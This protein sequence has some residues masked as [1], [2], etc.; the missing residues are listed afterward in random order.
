MLEDAIR[1]QESIF[2]SWE[3]WTAFEKPTVSPSMR[4]LHKFN[5]Q[6]FPQQS[7]STSMRQMLVWRCVVKMHHQNTCNTCQFQPEIT[8]SPLAS[9]PQGRE[10]IIK[11]GDLK[12]RPPFLLWHCWHNGSWP[13]CCS[14]AE[15]GTGWAS[16][17]QAITTTWK[18]AP[19]RLPVRVHA[20]L[21][22]P[23]PSRSTIIQNAVPTGIP[24][25]ARRFSF[26]GYG[27]M[28]MI[29]F[30][31]SFTYSHLHFTQ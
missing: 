9:S 15:V 13:I 2:L 19:Q 27:A 31:Q 16:V 25:M 20:W 26:T 30:F 22:S 17:L 24:Q 10:L 29:T 4:H 11:P 3:S 8:S 12:A 6:T 28:C 14:G 21:L 5:W 7:R 1:P 18:I 23:V